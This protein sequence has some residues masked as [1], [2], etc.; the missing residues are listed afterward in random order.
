ML[1][2]IRIGAYALITNQQGKFLVTVTKSRD[3]YI[4]NFPGGKVEINET[5]TA[6]LK[7]ELKEECNLNILTDEFIPIYFTTGL[8]FNPDFPNTRM[9]NLYML[10]NL[11]LQQQILIAGKEVFSL[12]WMDRKEYLSIDQNLVLSADLEFVAA[13]SHLN[14]NSSY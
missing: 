8:H 5:I 6:C 14:I 9:I 13:L 7:R 10:F 1:K 11:D 4:Y 12:V 3:R 2:N